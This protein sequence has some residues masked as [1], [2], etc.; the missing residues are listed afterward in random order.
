MQMINPIAIECI[1]RCQSEA[2]LDRL[3][4]LAQAELESLR[5]P[6]LRRLALGEGGCA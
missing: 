4:D 3:I 2:A 5:N 1:A 6:E